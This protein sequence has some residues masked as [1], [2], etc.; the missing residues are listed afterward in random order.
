MAYFNQWMW[1]CMHETEIIDFIQSPESDKESRSEARRQLQMRGVPIDDIL[2][3]METK[4]PDPAYIARVYTC[5]LGL[6]AYAITE[7]AV[8][9]TDAGLV[10]TE[11][12]ERTKNMLKDGKP[13]MLLLASNALTLDAVFN[14]MVRSGV[15]AENAEVMKTYMDIALRAQNQTRK[16][17]LALDQITNPKQP[18]FIGQQNNA[19]NQLVNN[20]VLFDQIE[21]M[22]KVANKVVSLI[23][24]TSEVNYENMELR[25][26]PEAVPVDSGTEALEAFYRPKD[27]GGEEGS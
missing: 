5:S 9:E 2:S 6:A 1:D 13:N 26:P 17:L 23:N 11:L 25:R 19:V 20:Q 21:E 14:Q 7:L 27:K 15:R 10:A 18:T 3:E 12:M 4:K 16:T 8:K 24:G 22:E